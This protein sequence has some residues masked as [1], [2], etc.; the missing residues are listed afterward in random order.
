MSVKCGTIAG[1]R[2]HQRNDES[3]CDAC[4]AAWREYG[5]EYSVRRPDVHAKSQWRRL[6][7][8]AASTAL[9]ARHRDEF[10]ALYTAELERRRAAKP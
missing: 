4:K 6:A 7:Y 2:K 8:S 9:I 10:H 1:Y 3:A 5:R